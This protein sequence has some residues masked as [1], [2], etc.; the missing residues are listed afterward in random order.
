VHPAL[1][2]GIS[3]VVALLGWRLRA[4]TIDGAIAAI[5]V[6]TSILMFTGWSG[7]AV[8]GTYF[9]TTTFVSRAAPTADPS[10]DQAD[11]E[12][13]DRWQ[14]LANGGAAGLGAL[15]ELAV[16]GLGIWVVSITLAASGADTWSTAFGRMSPRTPRDLRTRQPVP[17]G[18]S[19]GVTW[20]GTIGGLIGATLI[21]LVGATAT[22]VWTLYPA[23][24]SIGF[25]SMLLD[26]ALGSS[27][28]ARFH[29]D[30]CDRPTE[31]RVHG[32]GAASSWRRGWRWLDNN[33]VNGVATAAAGLVGL[34]AWWL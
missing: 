29:C 13:R 16:S 34:A 1:S 9:V 33:T 21:G 18:T 28:Q 6:G 10:S 12:T 15:L 23:A 27:V 4:L 22:G 19:G 30:R 14:V 17:S 32:C 31:R 8:L 20:F 25:G 3:T 2:L 5:A 24:A 11:T 26:S 7:F